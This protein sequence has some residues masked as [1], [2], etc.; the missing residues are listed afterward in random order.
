MTEDERLEELLRAAVRETSARSPSRDLWPAI[1]E[2]SR[3]SAA[4]SWLD[5]GVAA[6]VAVVL[7]VRPR[8]LWLLMYH[9]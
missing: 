8:W 6:I 9:L 3:A 7:L 1:V 2:R 4:W 5:V